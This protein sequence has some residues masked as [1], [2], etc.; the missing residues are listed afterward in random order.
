[1]A[2]LAI[3]ETKDHF[4]LDGEKFFYL[5]DTCWSAFTNPSYDE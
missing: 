1:M 5:A 3:F 4:L 2:R